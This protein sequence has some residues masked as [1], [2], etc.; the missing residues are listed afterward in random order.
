MLAPPSMLKATTTSEVFDAVLILDF[1]S[2]KIELLL[3][4]EEQIRS[5]GSSETSKRIELTIPQTVWLLGK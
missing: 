5:S 2:N 1:P 3:A 4:Y